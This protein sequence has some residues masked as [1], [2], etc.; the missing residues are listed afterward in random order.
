MFEAR[1]QRA[2]IV[3]ASSVPWERFVYQSYPTQRG[4]KRMTFFLLPVPISIDRPVRESVSLTIQDDSK[5]RF[6][7]ICNPSIH[8][9]VCILVRRG[10][11]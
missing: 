11:R 5:L 10:C 8:Q 6:F 2:D 3:E 7:W 4:S 1:K 9:Y